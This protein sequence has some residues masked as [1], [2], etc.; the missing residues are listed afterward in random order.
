MYTNSLV[1]KKN[2]QDRERWQNLFPGKSENLYKEKFHTARKIYQSTQRKCNLSFFLLMPSKQNDNRRSV[3][4]KKSRLILC[5]M[6]L[7]SNKVCLNFYETHGTLRCSREKSEEIFWRKTCRSPSANQSG[8][9]YHR[10]SDL[11]SAIWRLFLM[12]CLSTGHGSVF[13]FF[14]I[15][16][17]HGTSCGQ[18]GKNIT[19][20]LSL[21][22]TLS[23]KNIDFFV[24]LK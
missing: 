18:A 7:F 22:S 9:R 3:N 21:K 13:L 4:P 8:E 6:P 10:L 16:V 11:R 19:L 17:G 24:A 23:S 14:H 1:A 2:W 20:K 5:D 12:Y 15:R